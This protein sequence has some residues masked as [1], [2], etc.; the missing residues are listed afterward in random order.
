[1]LRKFFE[2]KFSSI[3][4]LCIVLC[5]F[6]FLLNNA[7]SGIATVFLI[8]GIVAI[9]FYDKKRKQVLFDKVEIKELYYIY[10]DVCSTLQKLGYEN[11]SKILDEATFLYELAYYLCFRA[12]FGNALS[13]VDVAGSVVRTIYTMDKGKNIQMLHS[14]C[15]LQF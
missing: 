1:M 14:A 4:F 7:S 11:C 9:V 5:G 3:V 8:A 12:Q 2:S 15:Q 10:L 6:A 13:T